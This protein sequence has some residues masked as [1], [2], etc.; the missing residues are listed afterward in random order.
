MLA[1]LSTLSSPRGP[2]TVSREERI[3]PTAYDTG[4]PDFDHRD[5]TIALSEAHES[6]QSCARF[7]DTREAHLNLAVSHMRQG[8]YTEA[9][10]DFARAQAREGGRKRLDENL[11]VFKEALNNPQYQVSA[12]VRRK[13]LAVLDGAAQPL[14]QSAEL[15]SEMPVGLPASRASLYDCHH[16]EWTPPTPP[17]N[18]TVLG[19][20]SK[21][22][23]LQRFLVFNPFEEGCFHQVD[24]EN[25]GT[26]KDYLSCGQFNK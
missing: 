1:V 18:L 6:F 20:C 13:C 25:V 22:L 23:L 15:A 12:S 10:N 8:Y 9:A 19:R 26:R 14:P 11:Q 21:E 4:D 16:E 3:L 5:I 2:R 24:E 17:S 7:T